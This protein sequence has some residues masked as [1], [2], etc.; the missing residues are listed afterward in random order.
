MKILIWALLVPCCLFSQQWE[1]NF[2]TAMTKAKT[3]NK[4]LLLVFAGSDWCAP[5]IRLEREIWQ[6]E[7]FKAFAADHYVLYKADFPRK[8]QNQLPP[9][10]ALAN[11]KLAERFNPQG[12]FPL[13]V[14]L[15]GNQIILGKTSYKKM[16]P[17]EYIGFLNTM[18]Q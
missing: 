8:K 5:C 12:Y 7:E 10:V 17:N 4:K 9:K 11:I 18:S 1:N 13:V 16:P 6:S 14:M 15:D 2:D 3:N